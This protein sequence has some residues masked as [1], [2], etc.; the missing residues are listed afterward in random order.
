MGTEGTYLN[1]IEAIYDKPIASIM[2]NVEKLKAFP[3]R[4]GVRQGCPLTPLLFNIFSEVLATALREEKEIKGIQ[5]GKKEVKLPLFSDDMIR[6]IENPKDTTRKLLEL[7][8]EFCKV[9]G[10]KINTQ[11]SRAFNERSEREIKEAIPFTIASTT[12]KY[13][14]I[15]LPEEAEDLYSENYKMLIKEIEDDTDGE[16]HHVL[17]LEES[18]LSK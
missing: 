18:I 6:Y 9:A 14:G 15:N 4:S 7:I 10:Y 2:L 17:G 16:I 5:I 8:H 3:R 13:L 12:I 1:I 11:I